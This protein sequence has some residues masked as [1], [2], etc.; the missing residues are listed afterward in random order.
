MHCP[1]LVPIQ[2]PWG[3]VSPLPKF[4][5][6]RGIGVELNSCRGNYWRGKTI[7]RNT[8]LIQTHWK[9]DN[10]EDWKNWKKWNGILINSI[11]YIF[12]STFCFSS[13][14]VNFFFKRLSNT[15]WCKNG[16][17]HSWKDEDHTTYSWNIKWQKCAPMGLNGFIFKKINK[18]KNIK[19]IKK[20]LGAV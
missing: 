10:L 16:K 1:F 13:W 20:I 8:V 5:D 14:W 2:R 12:K 6:M 15:N 3:G 9:S 11:I 17:W 18:N 19:M 7:R 4:A